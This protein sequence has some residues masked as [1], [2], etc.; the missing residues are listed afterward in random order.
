MQREFKLNLNTT[1]NHNTLTLDLNN[2]FKL[3]AFIDEELISK[4]EL[5]GFNVEVDDEVKSFLWML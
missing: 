2:N 1:I 4:Y 3:F 5:L